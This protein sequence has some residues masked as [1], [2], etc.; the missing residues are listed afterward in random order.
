MNVSIFNKFL[1]FIAFLLFLSNTSFAQFSPHNGDIGADESL[2]WLYDYNGS[3]KLG[4]ISKNSGNNASAPIAIRISTLIVRDLPC[5]L[6]H[7]NDEPVYWNHVK[8]LHATN[9]QFGDLMYI[10]ATLPGAETTINGWQTL[11]KII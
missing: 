5:V 1:V 10:E 7:C 6:G 4:V 9:G 11:E 3:F 2:E 8:D